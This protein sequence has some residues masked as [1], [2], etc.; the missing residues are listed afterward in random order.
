MLTGSAFSVVPKKKERTLICVEETHQGVAEHRVIQ[1]RRVC[2]DVHLSWCAAT[3]RKPSSTDNLHTYLEMT[4]AAGSAHT[5]R[6]MSHKASQQTVGTKGYIHTLSSEHA[7]CSVLDGGGNR[8]TAVATETVYLDNA[9]ADYFGVSRNNGG[10]G[11][12]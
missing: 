1:T 8:W 6:N 11:R 7:R 5:E 4:I 2:D 10:T 9:A 12:T 3:V